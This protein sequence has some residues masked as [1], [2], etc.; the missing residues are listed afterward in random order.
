MV[1][2]REPSPVPGGTTWTGFGFM[3]TSEGSTL[4]FD[5]PAI[6]RDG[7][8]DLVVRHEHVPNYP[9]DWQAAKVDLER[10][11]GPPDPSGK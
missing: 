5:V 9:G 6:F 1:I 7:E 8:Y 4:T 3:Q 10:I 2:R 11:D